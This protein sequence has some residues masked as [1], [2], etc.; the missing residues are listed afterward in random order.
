MSCC[1]QQHKIRKVCDHAS[2]RCRME[3]EVV[4]VY[5]EQAT[6]PLCINTSKQSH[7]LEVPSNGYASTAST[8]RSSK[9]T[10]GEPVFSAKGMDGCIASLREEAPRHRS[11]HCSLVTSDHRTDELP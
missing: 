2:A 5:M 6:L 4:K 9:R 7:Y 8:S 11:L 3:N 1:N 10:A